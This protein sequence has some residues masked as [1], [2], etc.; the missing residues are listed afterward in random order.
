[1]NSL[2]KSKDLLSSN[3]DFRP[4]FALIVTLTLMVLLLVLIMGLLSL[5][6]V[7]LRSESHNKPMLEA[8]QNAI[9]AMQLAIGQLQSLSGQDTRVTASA[10]LTDV[11][12]PAV[13]GVWRSWE[14]TD[15]ESTGR[16]IAPVY[17]SKKLAGD[18]S[19]EIAA[20]G[21]G[22]FLGWLTSTALNKTPDIATVPG[23]SFTATD[24]YIPLVSEG[25]VIIP[26]PKPANYT[27]PMI[28]MEPT[29]VNNDTG[30]FAWWTSGENQK[31]RISK[32]YEPGNDDAAGWAKQMKG[33]SVADPE[34]FRLESLLDTPEV[35]DKIISA[36]QA[37]IV[38][39]SSD[40]KVFAEFFH[41]FSTSATGL[42]T[43]TATGGWRKDLSLL[44]ENWDTLPTSDLPLFRVQPDEDIL[45]TRPV[46]GGNYQPERSLVY[47]WSDYQ[48]RNTSKIGEVSPI[49]SWASLANFSTLYKSMTGNGSAIDLQYSHTD[50]NNS[51]ENYN[52]HHKVRI[53]PIIAR[54]QWV[55]SHWAGPPPTGSAAGTL[56]PRLLVTPVFT[57]W[58]PY[59]V[60]ISYNTG[61]A[62]QETLTFWQRACL[63]NA[64]RYNINGV[65][66][67][68]YH[69]VLS[70]K[71]HDELTYSETRGNPWKNALIYSIKESFVLEPGQTILF[72]PVATP[73]VPSVELELQ[74]GY[75]PSGGHYFALR[76]DTGSTP[77]ASAASS[78][79][80]DAKFDS[81]GLGGEA[82]LYLDVLT[83]PGTGGNFRKRTLAYR[84]VVDPTI[85]AEMYPPI[86]GLAST[87]LG[88]ASS[89]PQPFLT[90]ILGPRTASN[91]FLP[92]K[93][94]VQTSP[95][96]NY[97]EMGKNAFSQGRYPGDSHPVNSLFDYSFRALSAVS[98]FTPNNGPNNSGCIITGFQSATG[99]HRCVLSELPNRPIQ[100]IPEL[101]SWD[102]RLDNPKPPFTLNSIANSDASPL[103]PKNAVWNPLNAAQ[104]NRDLQNDESYCM[105]HLLFDDWFFSSIAPNS[106]NFGAPS[107]GASLKKTYSDFLTGNDPLPNRAYKSIASD[108]ALAVASTSNIDTL[109][110][111]QIDT[112][113]SWR[114]IA[115]RLEVE[116]MF[117]VNSTSVQAWRALLGHAR[118][119]K[120][121]YFD[122]SFSPALSGETDYAFTRFS[123]SGDVEAKSS[124]SISGTF[125][126]AAEFAGYRTLDDAI[127]TRLAEEIV[128]QVRLR[129][130]FLSLSEFVNRQL[131]DVDTRA[132]GGAIQVALDTLAEDSSTNLYSELQTPGTLATANPPSPALAA[133]EF[134]KA[135]VGYNA[136][137]LPGWT[138]QA[139][140]LRPIAPVL[141]ARDDTFTIRAYGDAR[142]AEG[143]VTA[144]AF[145]EAVVRRT[146]NYVDSADAAD[147]TTL[148]TTSINK[149][150]GRRYEI[151]SFRWLSSSE[152]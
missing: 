60:R 137:G 76:S 71:N 42:L 84:M 120:V 145:C 5:S 65:Q 91:T 23:V 40:P 48:A 83:M 144:T 128:N 103:F 136:Y 86:T 125:Q 25:S 146:R 56:E 142:N 81:E 9:L 102:S 139:D 33:H 39:S 96:S 115:S 17:N 3:T 131:S 109:Y 15:H 118:G 8:R 54:I 104:G 138:R 57:L 16:P 32:P 95:L 69:S 75:R 10:Q 141:S 147:I 13:T 152:I 150:F 11:T 106:S 78:I 89:Q 1:M 99:L 107:G 77:P 97:A 119:Q 22:R 123:V 19:E 127:L 148:P 49:C 143:D 4:G 132:I 140:I 35:T 21:D 92:A 37:D 53:L 63:P 105:N 70:S 52:Y 87:T 98:D 36:S 113:T 14:G 93:G 58:N 135:A 108:T 126:G 44:T 101:T 66:N 122:S 151:V 130:P 67:T 26:S 82:G 129:G 110:Q 24:G 45:F 43:N 121:P 111:K 149:A 28:Y 18:A 88:E 85:A 80:V 31:A 94:F 100:S 41:D 2:K 117:N 73:A 20:A 116:G 64:L 59:N 46:S 27:E 50:G 61:L 55:Y 68:K 62:T 124:T 112:G 34:P 7:A 29:M 30:A 74:P 72:S 114:T 51:L 12:N 38:A 47:P 79:S 134:P 133:Y 6:S 90:T